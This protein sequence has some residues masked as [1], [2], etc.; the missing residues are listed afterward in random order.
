MFNN[1]EN[2]LEIDKTKEVPYVKDIKKT[3]RAIYNQMYC[4]DCSFFLLNLGCELHTD[5]SITYD[6]LPCGTFEPL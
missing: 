5:P 1:L 4:G 2:K 6:T 3:N